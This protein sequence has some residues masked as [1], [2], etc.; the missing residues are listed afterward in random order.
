M[1]LLVLMKRRCIRVGRSP[2][3]AL[4]LLSKSNRLNLNA[5]NGTKTLILYPW[6]FRNSG[7]RFARKTTNANGVCFIYSPELYKISV[8]DSFHL[9]H[10]ERFVF[11][12]ISVFGRGEDARAGGDLVFYGFARLRYPPRLFS[13]DFLFVCSRICSKIFL[14]FHFFKERRGAK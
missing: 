14:F 12:P 13:A 8:F 9:P 2:V 3:R 4:P 10:V 11:Y 1:I 5:R 6:G 7:S